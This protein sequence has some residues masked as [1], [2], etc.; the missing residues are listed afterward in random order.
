MPVLSCVLQGTV[1]GPLLFSL[2]ISDIMVDIDSEIPLFADDC[3]CYRQI[4]GIEDTVNLQ[5]D[6]NRLGK[7]ARNWGMKFQHSQCNMME[8]TRKRIRKAIATYTSDGTVLENVHSLKYLGVIRTNDLRWKS[9][10]GNICTKSN[11]TLGFL[12][13]NLSSCPR[14]V[15]EMAYKGLVRPILEM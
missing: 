3:G 2:Y 5:R 14:K 11:R 10:V 13:R 7:A 1:L 15:K 6:F 9:H 4:H 8:S 12:R